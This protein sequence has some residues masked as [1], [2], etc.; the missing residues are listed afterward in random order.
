[1][2]DVDAPG[3]AQ[4]DRRGLPRPR[5]L[6][7]GEDWSPPGAWLRALGCIAARAGVE[8][9]A[10]GEAF[11]WLL[12]RATI[13]EVDALQEFALFTD[14]AA[15]ALRDVDLSQWATFTTGTLDDVELLLARRAGWSASEVDRRQRDR[16]RAM[17]LAREA[18]AAPAPARRP[19]VAS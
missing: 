13:D 7:T 9:P 5:P 6:W 14:E 4:L 12:A 3:P 16:R 19:R 15:W 2:R 8:P 10:R 1:M 11:E 17:R 18:L